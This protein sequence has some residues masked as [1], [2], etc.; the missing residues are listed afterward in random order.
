[1]INDKPIRGWNT[2]KKGTLLRLLLL[3]LVFL[4]ITTLMSCTEIFELV[5]T[6]TVTGVSVNYTIDTDRKEVRADENWKAS[7]VSID[8]GTINFILSFEGSRW[9]HIINRSTGNMMLYDKD[10][11]FVSTYQCEKAS[12]NL[13]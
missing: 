6:D 7:S 4:L 9:L 5:C 1:M 2:I 3:I 11:R 12:L 13:H 10:N 8:R